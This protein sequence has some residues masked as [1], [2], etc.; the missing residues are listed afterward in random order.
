MT[1]DGR[2]EME[3]LEKEREELKK[4]A[5]V[6]D[7]SLE[8][9]ISAG[10]DG[11]IILWNPSAERVLGYSKGEAL[12]MRIDRLVPP[13]LKEAHRRG[14]EEFLSTGRGR[15]IGRAVE[16]EGIRKDGSRLPVE[17][18]LSAE[19]INGR[20]VFTAFIKDITERRKIEERLREKL[21]E[22]E[23]LNRLMVG[24]ELRMEELRK[25]IRT[26]KEKLEK[27]GP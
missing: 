23:R 21:D 27:S 18:S 12:G 25:E 14:F 24:R 6:I 15:F 4:L 17:M 20:W 5:A 3:E 26:L 11:R 9:I 22:T 16:L 8:A 19:K 13:E 2:T 10:E 7:T 1:F